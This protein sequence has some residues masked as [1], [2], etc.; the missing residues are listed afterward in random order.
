MHNIKEIVK[1]MFKDRMKDKGK[2]Y[3]YNR[4]ICGDVFFLARVISHLQII[5]LICFIN[6]KIF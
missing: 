6:V 4:S 2:G 3:F 1:K 5:F